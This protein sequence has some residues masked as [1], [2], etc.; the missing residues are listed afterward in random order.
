[1]LTKYEKDIRL[2]QP[3]AFEV[4]AQSTGQIEGYASTFGGTPDRHA[5]VVLP[6]A[7][8]RSLTRSKQTGDNPVMLWSH[9]QEEPIGRW[10]HMEE[11]AQ[12]L[13]VRGNLN[14]KTERGKEAFAHISA[15][16]AVELSIGFVTPEGGREYAG[17]GVFHLKEI[18]LLEISVVSIPANPLARITGVKHLSSKAEAVDALREIGLSRKAAARF[19]AGGW[20][21]LS[22]EDHQEKALNLAREIDRAIQ[23]MR[24]K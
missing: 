7:F 16:D 4:K 9:K 12:G 8:T 20:R 17:E 11:D 19:A 2:A 1:M 14:L 23:Q 21:A 13:Y 15:G 3:V 18:E 5:E 10:T 24:Q 6:G 22:G